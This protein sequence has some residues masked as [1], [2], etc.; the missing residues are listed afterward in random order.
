MIKNV[1]PVRDV[2][3][4]RNELF[5]TSML[6]NTKPEAAKRTVFVKVLNFLADLASKSRGS[7]RGCRLLIWNYR[8]RTTLWS[9][10]PS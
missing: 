9:E 8:R 6:E 2:L 1:F 10:T 3:P 7:T 4:V 5:L